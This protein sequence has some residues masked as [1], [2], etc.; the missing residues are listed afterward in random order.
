LVL[1]P[2]DQLGVQ[3]DQGSM[4]IKTSNISGV[5]LHFNQM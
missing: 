5:K 1:W 3:R 4:I 2:F